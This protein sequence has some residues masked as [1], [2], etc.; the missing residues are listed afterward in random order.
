MCTQEQPPPTTTVPL[1]PLKAQPQNL[2]PAHPMRPRAEIRPDPPDPVG[3]VETEAEP[4]PEGAN[5]EGAKPEDVPAGPTRPGATVPEAAQ[6][7]ATETVAV[8]GGE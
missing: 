4:A 7:A 2:K 6:I 5:P 8:P 1:T 3:V